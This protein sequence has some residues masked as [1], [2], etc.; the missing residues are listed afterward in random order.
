M[1][2]TT[3]VAK[4]NSGRVYESYVAGVGIG[5]D[6]VER[7]LEGLRGYGDIEGP[8]SVHLKEAARLVERALFKKL[9]GSGWNCEYRYGYYRC[10][11]E[12]MR[13][14]VSE[15]ASTRA[16]WLFAFYRRYVYKVLPI[17]G[18]LYLF[19][20]PELLVR[21][22]D[23]K[24]LIERL[25][26]QRLR[27]FLGEGVTC[28]AYRESEGRYRSAIATGLK[29]TAEGLQVEVVY[30]DG[31]SS[32]VRPERVRLKGN[33]LYL[34]RFIEGI[35]DQRTYEIYSQLQRQYSL[36]LGPKESGFTMGSKFKE[37]TERFV[38]EA[39]GSGVLP[40]TLSGVT[41]DVDD[42]ILEVGRS[43]VR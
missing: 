7:Y 43:E 18:E 21:G 42:K 3:R 23:F 8:T 37:E 6:D 26:E 10:Y 17:E 30:F 19:V 12:S 39:K 5:L 27:E 22:A 34:R 38:K 25:G 11:S 14:G 40:L 15:V 35:F 41:I 31:D 33:V 1:T 13:L 2:Y 32:L 24:S 29:D 9:L 28:N 20:K 16:P 36:S 4:K